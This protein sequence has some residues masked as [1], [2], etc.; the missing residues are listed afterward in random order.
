MNINTN[1]KKINNDIYTIYSKLISK[2]ICSKFF[3][4][5]FIDLTS[6]RFLPP[7]ILLTKLSQKKSNITNIFKILIK[8][9]HLIE[10]LE[11]KQKS[12]GKYKISNSSNSNIDINSN[13]DSSKAPILILEDSNIMENRALFNRGYY[14]DIYEALTLQDYN[15]V[16]MNNLYNKFILLSK[17]PINNIFEINIARFI[18]FL[19]FIFCIP[20]FFFLILFYIKLVFKL[21]F[22]K[23]IIKECIIDYI[24]VVIRT[25]KFLR[26]IYNVNLL[27]NK[28]KPKHVIYRK[29]FN[30]WGRLIA[31]ATSGKV[32]SS[33]IQHGIVNSSQ[34]GYRIFDHE[35]SYLINCNLLPDNIFTKGMRVKRQLSSISSNSNIHALGVRSKMQSIR[36]TNIFNSK[37]NDSYL[38]KIGLALQDIKTSWYII[39]SLIKCISSN[40]DR[41]RI[42]ILIRKHPRFKSIILPLFES[43]YHTKVT[44][45][46]CTDDRLDRYFS[47]LDCL[48][49]HSSTL[50]AEALLE[51]IPTGII[52]LPNNLALENDNSLFISSNYYLNISNSDN[53]LK[54]LLE[55]MKRPSHVA[56]KG[57]ELFLRENM[58]YNNNYDDEVR[59]FFK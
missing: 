2:I 55:H 35:A 41:I 9:S 43:N 16:Y 10:S 24:L 42:E 4:F 27:L 13:I 52:N 11:K 45:K 49:G 6:S 39:D 20:Q 57:R 15:I 36:H 32:I 38:I 26:T 8:R 3:S 18:V 33:A 48:I 1:V 30:A 5:Y 46:D 37:L 19:K 7:L 59:L 44:L 17:D 40:N 58:Y 25:P 50:L 14:S 51:G 29:E 21:P 28:Y 22:S 23:E 31:F 54:Q 53:M 47:G 34:V 56:M 12:I